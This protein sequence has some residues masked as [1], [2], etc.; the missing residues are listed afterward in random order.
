MDG[1]D[2]GA[3]ESN[4]MNKNKMEWFEGDARRL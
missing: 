4:L 1:G 3:Q 2:G